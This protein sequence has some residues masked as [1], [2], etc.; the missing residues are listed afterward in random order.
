[1]NKIII[2]K[3]SITLGVLVIYVLSSLVFSLFISSSEPVYAAGANSLRDL[4]EQCAGFKKSG[5]FGKQDPCQSRAS[6]LNSF[7]CDAGD[8][9]YQKDDPNAQGEKL[10]LWFVNPEIYAKCYSKTTNKLSELR[11]NCK[12]LTRGEG[13]WR[14]CEETQA[15]L[16]LA[17]GCSDRMFKPK[18]NDKFEL[19][20]G[21][22]DECQKRLEEAGAVRVVGANGE[23]ADAPGK[24][25]DST[26]GSEGNNEKEKEI[27]CESKLDSVLSWI[28]CP[29][30]DMGVDF[31]DFM[32]E[33]FIQPLLENVPVSTNS[34]GK[35]YKA[36]QD[37]RLL[38]NILLVGS[39]M[40][41]VYSQAKGGK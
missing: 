21:N 41:V 24:K 32:F 29:L 23:K 36:W 11:T 5:P 27:S 35:S 38:A 31:T 34:N 19:D 16:S 17:L 9:F 7:D 1:M 12:K 26:P 14:D 3:R 18:G 10:D 2:N 37:F 13:N 30:I 6:R 15:S 25:G 22:I 33:D 8:M 4:G 28:G 20:G 40:I 39:L